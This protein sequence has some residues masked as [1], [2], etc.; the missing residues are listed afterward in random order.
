[1]GTAVAA[2]LVPA[3]S[4]W[5]AIKTNKKNWPDKILLRMNTTFCRA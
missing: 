1:V 4:G 5:Q 2:A 3:I